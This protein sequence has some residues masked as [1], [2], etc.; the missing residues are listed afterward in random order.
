VPV[1]ELPLEYIFPDPNLARDDGLLAV[2][3]D[4]EPERLLLAYVRGIFPWY[5]DGLPILWHSPNP[6]FVLKLDDL[7]IGRS[8]RKSIKK[9]L[10]TVKFDSAFREVISAC[11]AAKRPEQ[12]GTWI[13]AEM[14]RGY[15][16]L[17]ELGYAHSTEVY[18]DGELVG[19]LYGV[20]IGEMYFGES[21]FAWDNDA[22]KIGFVV[23]CRQLQR[24]G[25]DLVDSQVYTDHVARFGAMEIERSRYLEMLNTRIRGERRVG[26]WKLDSD[27]AALEGVV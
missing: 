18:R 1:F 13:T 6:R 25:F 10:F 17:H 22:S 21:M 8:L 14:Q 12:D 9:Q 11:R 23:L 2:G 5:S 19:G 27:L 26:Y 24:W 15:E 3:G 7:K 20:A 16:R 4:L